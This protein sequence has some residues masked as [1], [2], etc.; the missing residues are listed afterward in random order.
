MMER[1][2]QKI[3]TFADLAQEQADHLSFGLP[4]NRSEEGSDRVTE[5]AILSRQKGSSLLQ[6]DSPF[7]DFSNTSC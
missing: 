5:I 6:K 4:Y 1:T 2:S 3:K 7:R